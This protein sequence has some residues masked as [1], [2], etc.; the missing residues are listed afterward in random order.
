MSTT[1]KDT[2]VGTARRSVPPWLVPLLAAAAGLA[3]W[4]IGAAV[5]VGRVAVSTA[6]GEQQVTA[7]S[8][9]VAGIIAG[10]LGCAARAVI[11]RLVRDPARARLVWTV[12][13]SL[14]LAI[15]LLGPL[16][17]IGAGALALLLAEHLVVGVVVIVGLR[18]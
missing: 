18:G 3:V 15:S 13:G 12:L 7:V 2:T 6:T 17:A 5:G 8:V 4:A 9:L 16:G 10:L 14:V 1:T 11:V